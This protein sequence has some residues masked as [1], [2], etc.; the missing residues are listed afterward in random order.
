[1][2]HNGGKRR[3]FAKA[4]THTSLALAHAAEWRPRVVGGQIAFRINSSEE[5]KRTR[6]SYNYPRQ[7]S[8][9]LVLADALRA[10][11]AAIILSG[12]CF[13]SVTAAA[14][15]NAQILVTIVL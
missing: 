1:M 2:R 6:V 15:S 10:L 5:V 4:I 14:F 11:F 8:T 13:F 3:P 9:K 12:V 7:T